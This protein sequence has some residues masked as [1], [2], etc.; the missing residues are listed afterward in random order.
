MRKLKEDLLANDH[1]EDI[2][3]EAKMRGIEEED[4]YPHEYQ[5]P[6][7]ESDMN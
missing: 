5:R 7:D 1:I 2:Q 4:V 3:L 6:I